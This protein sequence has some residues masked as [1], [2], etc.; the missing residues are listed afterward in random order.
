[1]AENLSDES[2]TL[3]FLEITYVIIRVIL[4]VR[5]QIAYKTTFLFMFVSCVLEKF[6]LPF[7]I[8]WQ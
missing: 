1:M 4:T 2:L 8:L 7:L 3:R 5:L 6:Y